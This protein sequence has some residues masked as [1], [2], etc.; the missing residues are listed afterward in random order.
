MSLGHRARD[1]R[2]FE[3]Q[4]RSVFPGGPRRDYQT[5]TLPMPVEFVFV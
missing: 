5:N 3:I 2:I 4:R 1:A